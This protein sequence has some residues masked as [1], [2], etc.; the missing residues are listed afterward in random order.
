MTLIHMGNL[1]QSLSLFFSK[2]T[3]Y[4]FVEIYKAQ[5]LDMFSFINKDTKTS[6]NLTSDIPYSI[7]CVLRCSIVQSTEFLSHTKPLSPSFYCLF[8]RLTWDLLYGALL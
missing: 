6:L 3:R 8:L 4:P 5:V 2:Q 7:P 1:C